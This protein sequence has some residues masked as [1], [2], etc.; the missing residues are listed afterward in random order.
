MYVKLAIMVAAV[1]G[2]KETTLVLSGSGA[3]ITYEIGAASVMQENMIIKDIYACSAGSIIG[4][5]IAM[6]CDLDK[7]KQDIIDKIGTTKV[8]SGNVFSGLYRLCKHG[9]MFKKDIR[10]KLIKLILTDDDKMNMAFDQLEINLNILATNLNTGSFKIFNRVNTPNVRV[11]DAIMASSAIPLIY[12]TVT[13]DGEEY[14]DGGFKN[15]YPY[16]FA[17]SDSSIGIYIAISKPKKLRKQPRLLGM[18]EKTL[19]LTKASLS[20]PSD[21]PVGWI[22]N[23]VFCDVTRDNNSKFFSTIT[24]EMFDLDFKHGANQA[25]S[26]VIQRS[27]NAEE[28]VQ[29]IDEIEDYPSL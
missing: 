12:P 16:R 11:V 3:N 1:K 5:A 26:F 8:Y 23:T 2:I 6:G 17:D 13:I 14:T 15:D 20:N 24:T 18:I 28:D 19:F 22:Q 29:R 4:L 27:L 7:F 10:M 9:Y 25:K 21:I